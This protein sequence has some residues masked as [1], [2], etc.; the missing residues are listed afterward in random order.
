[1]LGI[2]QLGFWIIYVIYNIIIYIGAPQIY[3]NLLILQI[4]KVP[5]AAMYFRQD[6]SLKQQ[7]GSPQ[8]LLLEV[9]TV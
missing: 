4:C 6:Y 8:L 3:W 2:A 1:M 7:F 5:D 9:I